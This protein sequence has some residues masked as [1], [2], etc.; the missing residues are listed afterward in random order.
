MLEG[1]LKVLAL[2]C[3]MT[4]P[5]GQRHSDPSPPA[6]DAICWWLAAETPPSNDTTSP[7]SCPLQEPAAV[8][9]A[10]V[11]EAS[12]QDEFQAAPAPAAAHPP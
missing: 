1:T 7:S 9:I 12:T 8:L 3:A 11:T 10:A 5:S 4:P 6:R 2:V